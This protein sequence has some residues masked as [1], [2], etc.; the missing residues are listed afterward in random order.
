MEVF[1]K[2]RVRSNKEKDLDRV[3]H[4]KGVDI[5]T[6]DPAGR[7]T[8]LWLASRRIGV[9]VVAER[10]RGRFLDVMDEE[11]LAELNHSPRIRKVL[12]E[13][14]A[15]FGEGESLGFGNIQ[16]SG[17]A[18]R[19]LT[20]AFSRAIYEMDDSVAGLRYVS[21]HTEVEECWAVFNDRCPVSFPEVIPLAATEPEDRAA[22]RAAAELLRLTLPPIWA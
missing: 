19:E 8:D 1:D 7:V 17:Q 12:S 4:L 9:G 13:H 20:Q 22:V 14:P 18:A 5:L 3:S 10:D 15:A 16:S 21:R 6:E 11:L 2:W